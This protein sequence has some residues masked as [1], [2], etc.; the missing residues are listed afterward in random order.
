[1][2]SQLR[3]IGGFRHVLYQGRNGEWVWLTELPP[4]AARAAILTPFEAWLAVSP[5][6]VT[7]S[8]VLLGVTAAWL[9]SLIR[10]KVRPALL[11]SE[12]PR[13]PTDPSFALTH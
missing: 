13:R 3:K 4:L 12:F 9:A 6:W 7:L 11:V 2:A 5:W 10:R 8:V 1:M